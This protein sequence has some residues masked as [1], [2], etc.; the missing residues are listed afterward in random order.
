MLWGNQMK[1]III[2]LFFIEI[3]KRLDYF[4]LPC[5]LVIMYRKQIKQIIEDLEKKIVF[6]VGPRQV[7]KTWLALEIGRLFENTTYLNYDSFDDSQIIKN[8]SWPLSTEL[9]KTVPST[10][11]P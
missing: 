5:I 2:R 10:R 1:Y 7:G 8:E 6:I 4:L 9:S 11:V 3:K